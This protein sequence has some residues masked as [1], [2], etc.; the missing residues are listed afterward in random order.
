MSCQEAIRFANDSELVRRF[1][2]ACTVQF[3]FSSDLPPRFQVFPGC[4]KVVV[5]LIFFS[6]SGLLLPGKAHFSSRMNPTA[7]KP[8]LRSN[9]VNI[10]K[11]LGFGAVFCNDLERVQSSLKLGHTDHTTIKKLNHNRFWNTNSNHTLDRNYNEPNTFR[12][13]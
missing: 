4:I 10:D 13:K 12:F 2:I 1:F 5:E 6:I 9:S 8:V 7:K 3:A 11:R